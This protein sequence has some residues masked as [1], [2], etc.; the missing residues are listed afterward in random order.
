MV[1]NGDNKKD[2]IDLV[3]DA[4]GENGEELK[5]EDVADILLMLL[6]AAHETTAVAFTSSILYLTRHPLL[7]AKAKKEQEE[8]VKARPSSQKQLSRKEIKKMIYLSQVIDEMLR[9]TNIAF[10]LF[11]EATKD[12]NINGLFIF[13]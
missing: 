5:D 9:R 13:I 4:K 3:L 6:F 2:L 8:I 11:R 1:K 10:S 12:V 7:F